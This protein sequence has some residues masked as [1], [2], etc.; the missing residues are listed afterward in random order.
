MIEYEKLGDWKYRVTKGFSICTNII[1]PQKIQTKFSTLTEK[2]RLYF[3][4]GFCW[5]GASGAYDSTNIMLASCAHDA[6]CN[7][8]VDGLLDYDDY[9]I[10]AAVLL[11]RICKEQGMSD[12]RAEYVYKAVVANGI[13]RY[14]VKYS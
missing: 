8:M 6:L 14:G 5:D 2:G 10:P 11:K 12:F 1:P 9:R 3:H 13:V 4:K 7:W